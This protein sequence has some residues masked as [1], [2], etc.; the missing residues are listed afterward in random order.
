MGVMPCSRKVCE[1]I[2]CDIYINSIGYVCYECQ[3]EFEI[4]LEK[5]YPE[6][7]FTEGKMKLR[8]KEFLETEK[9][10][11]VEGELISVTDFFLSHR[12]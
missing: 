7:E 8:L 11:Y 3:N 2:L 6:E 4:Y 5:R 1:G 10:T 9:D 12:R